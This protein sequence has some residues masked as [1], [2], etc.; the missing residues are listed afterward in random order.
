MPENIEEVGRRKR[1][2]NDLYV[3]CPTL[4]SFCSGRMIK[5]HD[6]SSQEDRNLAIEDQV[7]VGPYVI[8]WET[9]SKGLLSALMFLVLMTS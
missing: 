1:F 4:I 5:E 8:T 3:N 7:L 2:K 9:H 6:Q